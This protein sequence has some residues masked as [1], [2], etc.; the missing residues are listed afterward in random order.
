LWLIKENKF[1]IFRRTVLLLPWGRQEMCTKFCLE[2][3]GGRYHSDDLGVYGEIILEMDFRELSLWGVGW[4]Y[5]V[6]DRHR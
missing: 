5:M 1:L 3:L 2:N 4:I 6:Q